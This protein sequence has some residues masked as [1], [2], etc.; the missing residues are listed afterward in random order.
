VTSRPLQLIRGMVGRP[1]KVALI[2]L[3]AVMVSAAGAMS[4]RLPSDADSSSSGQRWKSVTWRLQ[5]F[6]R[7]IARDI[8]ELSWSELWDMTRAPGGFGLEAFVARGVSLD[9][10]VK[11]PHVGDTDIVIGAHLYKERCSSCHGGEG[12]GW[13]APA[14]NRPGYAH[15]DSDLAIYKVLRD[16]LPNS[17]MVTPG[18][19]R[20]E[21]WQV[22]GY[23]RSLQIGSATSKPA[24]VFHVDVTSAQLRSVDASTEWPTYSGSVNG[25]RYSE[26]ADITPAN[27]SQLRMLWSHQFESTGTI[28][29]TPLVVNG[30]MFI[31]LPPANVVA[32]D[33]KSGKAIWTYTRTIPADLPLCCGVVNRGVAMLGDTLFLGTLDGYLVAVNARTGRPMWEKLV[34]DPDAGYTLTG[35]PLIAGQLV[36]V[37]TAGG[38]YGIRGFVDAYDPTTGDRRWRFQTIPSPGD[39]GHDSWKNDAWKTGGGPTWV[40]GSYDPSLDLVYWGVGNPAPDFSGDVRPGDNLFTNSVIALHADTGRLAWYFQFTPHDEH[41]WDSTQTPILADIP[42]KGELRRVVCWPNRNGFYYVLDRTT[43]KF[44][45]GIPFVEI[46]WASG[47]DANGRPVLTATSRLSVVG[48]LVRPGANGGTN[49]QNPAFDPARSVVFVP[50]TEGASV[51]TKTL[52]VRRGENGLYMGSSGIATPTTE[53][54][55]A[56]DAATGVKKWEYFSPRSDAL[57]YSGL[58][59]TRGGLVFGASG[60]NVFALES[61]TGHERWAVP[62]GGHTRSAPVSFSREGRQVIA[63]TAGQTLFLFG[64]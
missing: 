14:L 36:V 18:L 35:A 17:A 59:A 4:L 6:G 41:D 1:A 31:T 44:I 49:W 43:G 3:I 40:T 62:L 11:S 2:A 15:G 28:E 46:N 25:H 53:V 54:V 32:I 21:R 56:L 34:A 58:L 55:R 47:L 20:L 16:G 12:A 19:S 48:Q 5:L 30:V 42:I 50:A 26:L 39:V 13:H 45:T 61:E 51:F 27:V 63:V 23:L 38:E 37:G 10:S 33:V 52:D 60:G 24:A 9:G 22:I 29:A 7:K 57:G 8:P 64:L